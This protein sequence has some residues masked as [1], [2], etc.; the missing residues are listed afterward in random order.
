MTEFMDR[1]GSQDKC[2]E[3]LIAAR[4]PRGFTCPACGNGMRSTFRR[5]G[6]PYWQCSRCRHQCSLISGTIFESSKLPLSRWFLAMHLLT[7]S[8][9]WVYPDLSDGFWLEETPAVEALYL[10]GF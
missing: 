5:E 6:R 2:E 3:A 1:Y 7:Q 10:C 4:W 9:N 8:K